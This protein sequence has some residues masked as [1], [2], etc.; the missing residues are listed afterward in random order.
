[1]AEEH[2]RDME[3]TERRRGFCL[4]YGSTIAAIVLA[5]LL[6]MWLDPLLGNRAPFTTYFA[7]I[8][9]TA[10]Y[11]GP[12]PSLMAIAFSALLG[13]YLFT[14]PRGSLA[15]YDLEHQVAVVLF[16]AVGLFIALLSEL[17]GVRLCDASK[18]KRRRG[19]PRGT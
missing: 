3:E 15:I 11:A 10:W 19:K 17:P 12:G 7:A 4:C 9:F 6:R 1:M 5:T 18:P 16:I 13:A 14:P 8:M 2:C